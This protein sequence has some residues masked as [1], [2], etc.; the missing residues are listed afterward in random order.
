MEVKMD[1][2]F[3]KKWLQWALN[4]VQLDL[5]SLPK[6]KFRGRCAEVLYFGSYSFL[7]QSFESF[8]L[9]FNLDKLPE[10]Q[11]ENFDE[12][13]LKEQREI[14]LKEPRN[15]EYPGVTAEEAEE[16]I[17]EMTIKLP[18][19]QKALK[20]FFNNIEEALI[21]PRVTKLDP[22]TGEEHRWYELILPETENRL[23]IGKTH[24]GFS[25]AN[26][27]VPKTY[28]ERDWAILNL[29]RLMDG[30]SIYAIRKCQGCGRYFL[31]VSAREKIYCNFAC[32]S[33]SI[34]HKKYEEL[35]KHPKKYKAHLKKYRKYSSD[36]YEKLRKMQYG[37]NVRIQRRR[38]NRKED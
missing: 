20:D 6:A 16:I 38:K 29:A 32:A 11:I 5:N 19:I 34:A 7:T 30:I 21:K 1:F 9:F 35:K 12:I 36:R 2:E 23:D 8:L 25:W 15:Q 31:N 18:N 3:R 27:S 4:F 22:T 24:G 26:I 17:S 28:S 37:P 13:V 10:I 33:R 14:V